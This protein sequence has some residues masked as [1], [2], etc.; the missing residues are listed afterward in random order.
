MNIIKMLLGMSIIAI[1]VITLNVYMIQIFDI[2]AS[3][4][5]FIGMGSLLESPFILLLLPIMLIWTGVLYLAVLTVL[6][7]IV[8][9][10]PKIIEKQMGN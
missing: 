2:T 6:I 5:E 8:N 4:M 7:S 1:Y 9:L 10:I 3:F